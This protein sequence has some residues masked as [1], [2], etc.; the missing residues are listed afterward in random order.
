MIAV[1][2]LRP[3]KNLP[4]LIRAV[5][6]AGRPLT[7]VGKGE[8]EAELRALAQSVGANVR[9]IAQIDNDALA[10]LL[11]D[12]A[13]FLS[14]ARARPCPRPP[15]RTPSPLSAPILTAT[16]RPIRRLVMPAE[17]GS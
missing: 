5:A 4:E 10:A 8:Q 15:P 11:R 1:G 12:H 13:R 2:R 9:F 14:A 3:Q 6:M 7:L 17:P 16:A